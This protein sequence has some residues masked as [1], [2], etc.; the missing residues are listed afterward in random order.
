M[1]PIACEI[2]L[3]LINNVVTNKWQQV[4]KI[5]QITNDLHVP[6]IY[7]KEWIHVK[8][9][10]LENSSFS[11]SEYIAGDDEIGNISSEIAVILIVFFDLFMFISHLVAFRGI[12]NPI[13]FSHIQYLYLNSLTIF[14]KNLFYSSLEM[15]IFPITV[16]STMLTKDG[17]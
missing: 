15:E 11:W 5:R 13:L 1:S 3:K 16:K 12:S 8:G 9:Q 4:M 14:K 10:A 2:S 6:I 17:K 7:S